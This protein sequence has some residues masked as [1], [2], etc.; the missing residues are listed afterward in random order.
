MK[1]ASTI[2]VLFGNP[3]A[4]SLSPLM[5]NAAYAQM[6]I[7]ARYTAYCP[8][9]IEEAIRLMREERVSGASVTIPFKVDIMKYLDHI[10]ESAADIGAVNTVCIQDGKLVGHNT[11]WQGF[12]ADLK[13]HMSIEGKTFVVIGAGG[14]AR[15]VLYGLLKERGLPL[16]VNRTEAKAIALAD[17]FDC[18]WLS[19][20]NLAAARGECLINVTS[21]GMFPRTDAS[22]VPERFLSRFG[23]VVDIVYNPLKTKLLCEAEAAGCNIHTGLGMFVRQGAEQI[24]L[25]TGMEPPLAIMTDTVRAR[26]EG[27]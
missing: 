14:A 19:L 24:R 18:P 2:Y 17:E 1:T 15:A 20:D 26:L 27:R 22:P 25:W 9:D 10:E 3:V 8:R 6:G 16:I 23:S 11:D 21:S 12:I 7:D 13:T 5:H 4:H